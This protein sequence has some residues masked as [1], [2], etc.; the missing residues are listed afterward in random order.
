MKIY[1]ENS[2]RQ[3]EFWSSAADNAN[4]LTCEQLDTVEAILED[5]YPDGIDA[6]TLND[7]FRFDFDTVR[8]W[9]GIEDEDEDEE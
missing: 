5:C 9:L 7:I 3:F 1:T 6:T 8:E 2:L 4:S